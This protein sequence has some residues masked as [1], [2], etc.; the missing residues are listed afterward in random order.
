[1]S[2]QGQAPAIGMHPLLHADPSPIALFPEGSLF[3]GQ[4]RM[5]MRGRRLA[6]S[7]KAKRAPRLVLAAAQW[8][9]P[10]SRAVFVELNHFSLRIVC[11]S[12]QAYGKS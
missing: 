10:R 12:F 8:P 3:L 2:P 5:A 9:L 7:C 6:H 11:S 4:Q 1:M